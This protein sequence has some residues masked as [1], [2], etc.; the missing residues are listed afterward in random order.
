MKSDDLYANENIGN[1][2]SPS[3]LNHEARLHL[4]AGFG[5]VWIAGELSNVSRPGS[6]HMYFSL[7]DD[8]AQISCA[9]FRSNTYGLDFKPENGMLVRARGRVS[10]FEARLVRGI[11]SR[12]C[13]QRRQTQRFR[14]CTQGDKYHSDQKLLCQ[15]KPGEFGTEHAKNENWNDQRGNRPT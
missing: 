5:R 3:E 11:T 15:K 7:K 1:V 4:E 10:L 6:G 12:Q 2:Y 8:K 13:C 9:L 14:K